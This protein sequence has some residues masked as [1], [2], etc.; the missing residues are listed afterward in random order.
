MPGIF[1]TGQ[2]PPGQARVGGGKPPSTVRD[3]MMYNCVCWKIEAPLFLF[4]LK[5]SINQNTAPSGMMYYVK[6]FFLNLAEETF[7]LHAADDEN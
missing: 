2:R 7:V 6:L 5:R 1:P 3:E 4:S